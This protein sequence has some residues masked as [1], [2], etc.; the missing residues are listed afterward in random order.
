MCSS[1]DCW[2]TVFLFKGSIKTACLM[3]ASFRIPSYEI[4]DRIDLFWSSMQK[5]KDPATQNLMYPTLCRLAKN[6]HRTISPLS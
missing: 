1:N 6:Q 4:S 2:D 5:L 3:I